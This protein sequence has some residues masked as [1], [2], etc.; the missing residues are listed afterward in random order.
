MYFI[1]AGCSS[2]DSLCATTKSCLSSRYRGS[3]CVLA[4]DGPQ[5]WARV[6]TTKCHLE[7]AHLSTP[8]SVLVAYVCCDRSCASIASRGSRAGR[9]PCTASFCSQT[10]WSTAACAPTP[11]YSALSTAMHA[12]ACR[13]LCMPSSPLAS[14]IIVLVLCASVR[15]SA[16]DLLWHR[17]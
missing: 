2:L 16:G 14:L 17:L 13:L 9:P 5:G 12:R 11:P 1:S 4:C 8:T 15:L 3:G 7:T 10:D 6:P